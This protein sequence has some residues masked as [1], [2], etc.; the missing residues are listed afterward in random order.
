M[1]T[2][3]RQFA[4]A[5]D[6]NSG[7]RGL[8]RVVG[9]RLSL[10]RPSQ[11]L[12]EPLEVSHCALP[13]LDVVDLCLLKPPG[14]GWDL[15]ISAPSRGLNL[16]FLCRNRQKHRRRENFWGRDNP[17][18]FPSRMGDESHATNKSMSGTVRKSDPLPSPISPFS[19]SS[20]LPFPSNIISP[21]LSFSHTHAHTHTHTHSFT[22]LTPSSTARSR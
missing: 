21:P 9:A 2:F 19:S 10:E 1:K 20:R 17:P 7:E 3:S 8:N 22:V 12:F 13:H 6:K 18:F 11:R 16:T 4:S 15:P 5:P 14:P